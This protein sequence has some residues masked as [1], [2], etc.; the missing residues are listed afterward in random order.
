MKSHPNARWSR[1]RFWGVPSRIVRARRWFG[2]LVLGG[3]IALAVVAMLPQIGRML[4]RSDDV[5]AADIG[6]VLSGE[7]VTRTEAARDLFQQRRIRRIVVFPE[8]PPD[9]VTMRI[10]RTAGI[11]DAAITVLAE[12]AHG[13]IEEARRARDLFGGTAGIVVITSKYASR[14]ACFIFERIVRNV[15]VICAPTPYD[16]FNSDLWWRHH[17]ALALTQYGKFAGSMV[18]LAVARKAD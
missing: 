18:M 10:L 2:A 15:R 1:F 16:R 3:V 12:P 4:V 6:L 14:R 7:P 5:R 11:P 8:V 9:P 17:P 13:T